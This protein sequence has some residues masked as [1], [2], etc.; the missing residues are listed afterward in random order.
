MTN[1]SVFITLMLLT[2]GATL[3]LKAWAH[4][5]EVHAESAP[6]VRTVNNPQRL[7]DGRVLLP[8]EAQYRL[9]VR[10]QLASESSVAKSIELN[11]HVVMDPNRGGQLQASSDGRIKAPE[12]G[13]PALG[14]MV[15][16]GQI[17]AWVVPTVSAYELAQ[18]QADLAE[19]NSKLALARQNL[20]R[21]QQLVNSVP[22]KDIQAAEAE[23]MALRGRSAAL[24]TVSNGEAMRAPVD[25]V[26]AALNVSN[27]QVVTASDVLFSVIAPDGMQIEALAYDP[28]LVSSLAGA[29]YQ[30]VKLRY[31]GG[32]LVLRDG[33]LPL[34]F[35][36]TQPLPLALGQTV[37]LIAQTSEVNTGVVLPASSV[38]KNSANESVV[39]LHEQALVFRAVVVQPEALDGNNVLVKQIPP[40]SRV[41]TQG[42][43]LLNQIR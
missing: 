35:A 7:P 2:T 12:N 38:V 3:N 18:Q 37:R 26:L 39:W 22:G 33:A 19:T 23:V 20:Q 13:L 28:A 43:S 9:S 27:G 17:L 4:G 34:R 1:S 14:S 42:A 31:L 15:S 32:A 41:V 6:A 25:G 29:T 16:K 8:K 30:G 24:A 36:P 5:D 11:G 21:L 10:T 40:G